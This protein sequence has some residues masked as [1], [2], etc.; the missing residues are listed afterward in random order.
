MA[1][2]LPDDFV[3]FCLD[4]QGRFSVEELRVKLFQMH[5]VEMSTTTLK[6]RVEEKG[7]ILKKINHKEKNQYFYNQTMRKNYIFEK[8]KE[9]HKN[10]PMFVIKELNSKC[11]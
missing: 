1:K 6:S 2:T 4:N 9:E 8:K 3:D 11:R 5:K 10:L 7:Y